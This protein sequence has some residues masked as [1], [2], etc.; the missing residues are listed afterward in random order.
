MKL[1]ILENAGSPESELFQSVGQSMG[2]HV[3]SVDPGRVNWSTDKGATLEG[4]SLTS[5]Y[6][7]VVLRTTRRLGVLREVARQFYGKGKPVFGLDAEHAAYAQDKLSDLADL[8]RAGVPIPRTWSGIDE[9]H[10][11]A[12]VAKFNR[13]PEASHEHPSRLLP[14]P[15]T[16][17]ALGGLERVTAY[18]QE[19][20]PAEQDWRILLCEGYALPF[21]VVRNLPP[22]D[23]RPN[24]SSGVPLILSG[25]EVPNAQELTDLAEVAGAVLGRPCGTVTLRHGADGSAV[26]TGVSRTSQLALGEVTADVVRMYLVHWHQVM[27]GHP[28]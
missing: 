22:G 26:V 8:R 28:L 17:E 3:T 23:L 16:P 1:L 24:T 9:V 21:V 15:L 10:S 18:Y 5:G 7:A 14:V 19:F 27:L 12:V 25:S 20:L 4:L 13:G 2:A 6:D 11:G